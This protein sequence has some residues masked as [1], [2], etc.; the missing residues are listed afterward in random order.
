MQVTATRN[1]SGLNKSSS[2]QSQRPG[3][4]S[5]GLAWPSVM[6]GTWVF[7]HCFC[8]HCLPFPQPHPG[9][10]QW[11]RPQPP[12][13]LSRWARPRPFKGLPCKSTSLLHYPHWRGYLA[14]GQHLV[15]RE[16]MGY[17]LPSMWLDLLQDTRK[18]II[19]TRTHTGDSPIAQ[20]AY[21]IMAWGVWE[22]GYFILSSGHPM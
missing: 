9:P 5:P 10:G 14:L 12:G 17:S 15:A 6:S 21:G 1:K 19:I 20:I 11:L 8:R 18:L 2:S 13:P 3:A 7:I 16:A 4:G 22:Q